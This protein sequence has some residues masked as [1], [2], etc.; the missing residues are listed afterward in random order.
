MKKKRSFILISEGGLDRDFDQ[1]TQSGFDRSD[2]ARRELVRK[3][4]EW[5]EHR[6]KVGVQVASER[7]SISEFARRVG[8]QTQTACKWLSNHD[9]ELYRQLREDALI[10]NVLSPEKRL[11][12]LVT[13]R[14]ALS[15]G[16]SH[17]KASKR[18][19]IS[20]NRMRIWLQL[21]APDGID[22][23][24]DDE[25]FAVEEAED[26]TGLEARPCKVA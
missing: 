18:C 1:I 22:Q 12:R 6:R 10:H 4:P 23:A 5:Q 21:W 15:E 20:Q 19:G 11:G 8:I 17:T 2:P 25:T 13:Y 16:L 7:G 24:I 3:S 9:E 14:E 26:G